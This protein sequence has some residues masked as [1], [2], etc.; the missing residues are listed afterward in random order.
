MPT[1]P[2]RTARPSAAVHFAILLATVSAIGA[3]AAP[4]AAAL[5]LPDPV[6]SLLSSQRIDAD[7]GGLQPGD[8][9]VIS[10][11][12]DAAPIGDLNGDGVPELAVTSWNDVDAFGEL[13]G[14]VWILFL[15]PDGTVRR[16]TLIT[17]GRAGLDL[18]R[19]DALAFSGS[20]TGIGDLDG[21]G[22][23]DLAVGSLLA[24]PPRGAGP[25]GAVWILFLRPDGRVKGT[26]RISAANTPHLAPG[27]T[28]VQLGHAIAGLGDVD[29]DGRGDLAVAFAG[30]GPAV[31][32]GHVPTDALILFLRRDGS[33]RRSRLLPGAAFGVSPL[34]DPLGLG[35]PQPTRFADALAGLGDVDGD[36]TPDLA[37]GVPGDP[38]EG[39][40][41]PGYGAVF[42]VR[43]N[44]DGS[45][46]GATK[47]STGLGGFLDPATAGGAAPP[48]FRRFGDA[49]GALGD[50][51]G[52]GTP[53]L[54]VGSPGDGDD[55]HVW[56]LRLSPV[57]GVVG[58]VDIPTVL[59]T[60][61]DAE[62]RFGSALAS[63][64]DLDG[65]GG[66]ELLV[67]APEDGLAAQGGAVFEG[68]AHV[69][70]LEG[71]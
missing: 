15:D 70:F 9:T 7:Q 11:G 21:D 10:F 43:L 53:D 64:G 37:V 32:G 19:D 6:G 67:G 13:R 49:L 36:G 66:V 1:R 34:A 51:D 50:V 23:P 17:A 69:L 25:S 54:A 58:Q 55:E 38:N 18:S 68:A 46:K 14:Q 22:V 2:F 35:F 27:R 30:L 48:L 61:G 20:V 3:L 63:P 65:D 57:G 56:I 44:P 12:G 60:P 42:V 40:V 24:L 16:R 4:R 33:V 47:I 29:G 28:I 52:D 31:L 45:V 5:Q 41:S 8:T 26:H 39:G 71:P 62:A 59:V